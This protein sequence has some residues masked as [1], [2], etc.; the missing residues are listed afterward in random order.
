MKAGRM[1]SDGASAAQ[2]PA[3]EGDEAPARQLAPSE[4]LGLLSARVVVTQLRRMAAHEAGVRA[5]GDPED[6]HKMRVATRRLRAAIGMFRRPLRQVVGK[7]TL[8]AATGE[9]RLLARALGAVRDLDVAILAIKAYGESA[10]ADDW[11]E[12]EPMVHRR[13]AVYDAARA[14]LL[15]VLDSGVIATLAH[16]LGEPLKG[17]PDGTQHLPKQWQAGRSRVAK[18]APPIMM[19]ALK[20]VR[21]YR[22]VLTEADSET[23]HACRIDC[24]RL[25]Y[26]GEFFRTPYG[27]IL[28]DLIAVATRIQ[29]DLGVVHDCDV[30]LAELEAGSTETNATSP[31]IRRLID[32]YQQ[33]RVAALASFTQRWPGLP[34][35]RELRRSMCDGAGASLKRKEDQ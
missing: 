22:I 10:P 32:R 16:A 14:A 23:L 33:T 9:V 30:M 21:E 31:A 5:G 26:S 20:R 24:K 28:D 13:L 3:A 15:A 11:P 19:R 35:P 34:R 2:A 7:Q 6:V 25:R 18:R 17:L 12:I 1:V 8:R 4:P 29:D 27:G